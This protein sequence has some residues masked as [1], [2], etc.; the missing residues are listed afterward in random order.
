M[1]MVPALILMPLLVDIN[2]L[3]MDVSGARMA[4]KSLWKLKLFLEG[5]P[6]KGIFTDES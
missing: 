4:L 2:N 1:S 5:F 6:L 3:E